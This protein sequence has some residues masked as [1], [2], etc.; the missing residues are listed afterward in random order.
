MIERDLKRRGTHA[1]AE[2]ERQHEELSRRGWL[3]LPEVTRKAAL[4]LE[5]GHTGTLIF[6]I[7]SRTISSREV[8]AYLA[9]EV[10]TIR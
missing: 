8:P 9:F 2:R 10:N 6:A 3:E 5:R 1:A 7:S 4:G